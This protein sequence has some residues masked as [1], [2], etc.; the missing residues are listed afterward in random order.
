[1]SSE[2][3]WEKEE[4]MR[5]KDPHLFEVILLLTR[6]ISIKDE[7]LTREGCNSLTQN[8]IYLFIHLFIYLFND[9]DLFD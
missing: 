5:A 2:A 3:T 4:E 1:M 6:L 7:L 9:T 8:H